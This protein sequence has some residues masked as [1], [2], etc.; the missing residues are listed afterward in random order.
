ML[1]ERAASPHLRHQ[2]PHP[3]QEEVNL[4]VQNGGACFQRVAHRLEHIL[5]GV[6]TLCV[7][8]NAP[9]ERK[10]SMRVFLSHISTPAQCRPSASKIR[11]SKTSYRFAVCSSNSLTRRAVFLSCPRM[12]SWRCL[13]CSPPVPAYTRASFNSCCRPCCLRSL[14]RSSAAAPLV[15]RASCCCTPSSARA[16]VR[17]SEFHSKYPSLKDRWRSLPRS[18]AGCAKSCRRRVSRSEIC[19]R[20]LYRKYC[21]ACASEGRPLQFRPSAENTHSLLEYNQ[22]YH[23]VRNPAKLSALIDVEPTFGR[24]WP[25]FRQRFVDAHRL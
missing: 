7:S 22:P 12:F 16:A 11:S 24:N 9:C 1:R 3:N 6:H 18:G 21:V 20:P 2:L 14:S 17:D 13:C 4:L 19:R 23:S 15:A 10:C 8:S 5:R 25:T